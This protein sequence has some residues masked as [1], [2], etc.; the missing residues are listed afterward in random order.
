MLRTK[1]LCYSTLGVS[2]SDK[3]SAERLQ[4]L[5]KVAAV[6]SRN[7]ED[8]EGKKQSWSSSSDQAFPLSSAAAASA[9]S[10]HLTS[11]GGDVRRTIPLTRPLVREDP[12]NY[13]AALARSIRSGTKRRWHGGATVKQVRY[14]GTKIR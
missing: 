9:K 3:P 5:E 4:Q 14:D 8:V 7:R 11:G 12:K 2:V 10:G 6:A 1:D 13:A